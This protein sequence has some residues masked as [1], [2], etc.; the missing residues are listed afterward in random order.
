MR[1]KGVMR[2]RKEKVRR[3]EVKECRGSTVTTQ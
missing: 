2:Q 1:G 3:I